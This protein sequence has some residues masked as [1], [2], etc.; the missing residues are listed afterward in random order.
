MEGDLQFLLKD[1]QHIAERFF[2]KFPCSA[3]TL[4]QVTQLDGKIGGGI[5]F[6]C[7]RSDDQRNICFPVLQIAF[8]F[9]LFV[10]R[11][12]YIYAELFGIIMRIPE[13]ENTVFFAA[14][15]RESEN[16]KNEGHRFF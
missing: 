12:F 9:F 8:Q 7:G 16:E 13:N 15:S 3:I 5:A 2:L 6:F 1:L 10:F 14:N 11:Q 4:R